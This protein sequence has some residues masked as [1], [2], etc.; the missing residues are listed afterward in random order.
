DPEL[1][2]GRDFSTRPEIDEALQ[3]RFT[4]GERHSTTL[5][6]DLLYVAVPVASGGRVLGAVR[7]T[8]PRSALDERI[9]QNWLR[10]GVLAVVVLAVTSLVGWLLSR[11]VSRPLRE[12]RDASAHV[13]SGVLQTRV[14]DT[15]GPPEVRQLAAAFN[16]M[17][18]RV[19]AMIAQEKALTGDISHQLR[20]PLTALRLRL[21]ALELAV[22]E[23]A[24]RDLD[25]AINET[26][27]LTR[28][29]EALLT[30]ARSTETRVEPTTIDAA[31]VTRARIEMWTPFADERR[32][33]L[34]YAGPQH[35]LALA[36]SDDTLDQILDNFLANALEASAADDTVTLLVDQTAH[37]VTVT[38]RDQG[39]GMSDDEIAV[40]FDRFFTTGGTG[41]GLAVV[42]RLAR[43]SGGDAFLQRAPERGLEAGVRLPAALA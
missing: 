23:E 31:A 28:T 35:A 20:T 17:S 33:R 27:R 5:N 9:E 38:V 22:G 10:L 6:A 2:V 4:S 7:I 19:E 36:A 15:R 37:D 24:Q 41:L 42:Q 11:S 34:R 12:L 40:A 25:A 39:P 14:D 32:V 43:A 30:I 1:D 18:T 16:T 29:L 26:D 13:A 8:Y 3:G 21:E